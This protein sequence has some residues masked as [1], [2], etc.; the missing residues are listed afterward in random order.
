MVKLQQ[1]G[2]EDFRPLVVVD[3]PAALSAEKQKNAGT[4][5][6]LL[7][8]H[9]CRGRSVLVQFWGKN[10]VRF[11]TVRFSDQHHNQWERWVLGCLQTDACYM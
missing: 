2:V 10:A 3:M 1:V 4:E 6:V 5:L 7:Q 9:T 11:C 8:F